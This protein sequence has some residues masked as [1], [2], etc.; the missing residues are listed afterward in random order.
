MGRG[1][2]YTMLIFSFLLQAIV[3]ITNLMMLIQMDTIGQR[4]C[5]NHR[6]INLRPYRSNHIL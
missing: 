1:I 5:K 2:L 3:K 4:I 6:M